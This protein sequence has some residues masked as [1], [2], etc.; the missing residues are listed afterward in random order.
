MSNTDLE[1][2]YRK[3]VSKLVSQLKRDIVEFSA[4]MTMEE[5]EELKM[6]IVERIKERRRLRI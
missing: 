5:L 3:A 4:N 6:T 1:D 2:E